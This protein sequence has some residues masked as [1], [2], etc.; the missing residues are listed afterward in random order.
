M[1]ALAGPIPVLVAR[2]TDDLEK[3]KVEIETAD[4]AAYVYPADVTD[5][6]T[7]DRVVAAV[8]SCSR[9]APPATTGRDGALAAERPAPAMNHVAGLRFRPP[10]RRRSH[11]AA[12]QS[13]G[14]V[15][16][17]RPDLGSREC[18]LTY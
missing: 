15:A 13:S 2:R 16:V 6:A 4:G 7:P 17:E 8:L 9:P 14:S 5:S 1:V 18:L 11:P 12:A 3:A 10:D